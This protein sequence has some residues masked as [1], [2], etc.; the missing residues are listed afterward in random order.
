MLIIKKNKNFLIKSFIL[1]QILY[2]FIILNNSIHATSTKEFTDINVP[3]AIV[4][5]MESGRILF[6]KNAN[7]KRKMASLT[8][9]MTSILLVENCNLD[10]LIEVPKEAA[11][12]GGSTV[13][14]KK[15][16][17]VTARSLLYGML[18]PSRK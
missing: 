6:E 10:E 2:I 3:A 12:I 4:M 7:E 18:L 15:G 13:G 5:D 17:K 9:I 11:Y 8:K 14:L 16:D 1:F